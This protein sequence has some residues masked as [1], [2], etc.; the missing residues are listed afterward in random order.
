MIW[1]DV[2]NVYGSVPHRLIEKATENFWFSEEQQHLHAIFNRQIY[3]AVAKIRSSIA[4]GCTISV[5]LFILVMKTILRSYTTVMN[6][7][8][9]A[10]IDDITENLSRR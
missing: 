6:P 3:H 4:A 5:I 1:L 2:A 7:S 8:L 10:I 9:K